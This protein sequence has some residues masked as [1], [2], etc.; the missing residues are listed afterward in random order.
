M[1]EAC[2]CKRLRYVELAAESEQNGQKSR[3][4]PVEVGCSGFI[5]KST[6]RL[7]KDM[8]I[9]GQAQG[10]AL[11]A[12]SGAAERARQWLWIKRRDNISLQNNTKSS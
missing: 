1:D 12:L 6:T 9:R 11:K 10:Q 7:L 4:S 3:V 5:G 2:E 8:G